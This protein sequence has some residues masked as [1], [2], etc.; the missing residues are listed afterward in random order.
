M[1]SGLLGTVFYS[2]IV[3]IAGAAFGRPLWDWVWAKFMK[4]IR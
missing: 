4:M 2:V 1:M 3:F